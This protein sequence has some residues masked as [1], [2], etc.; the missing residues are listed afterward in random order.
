MAQL[1]FQGTV[2]TDI[3][4][5]NFGGKVKSVVVINDNT[6]GSNLEIF[7]NS[8]TSSKIA[9]LYPGEFITLSNELYF[10]YIKGKTGNVNYRI[11]SI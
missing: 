5:I 4:Q 2:S 3:T 7:L 10:I 11:M 8:D 1:Y 6:T 9:E